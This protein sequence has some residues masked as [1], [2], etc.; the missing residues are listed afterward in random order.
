MG[1]VWCVVS[2]KGMSLYTVY[3]DYLA[4]QIVSVLYIVPNL[5]SIKLSIFLQVDNFS[6]HIGI[7]EVVYLLLFRRCLSWLATSASTW[8]LAAATLVLPLLSGSRGDFFRR[9]LAATH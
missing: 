4:A 8:W 6:V 9:S 7:V 1:T 2:L 5:A 3:A